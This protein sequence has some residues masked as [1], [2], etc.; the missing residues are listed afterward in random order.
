MAKHSF[1]NLN[2][3]YLCCKRSRFTASLLHDSKLQKNHRQ[4]LGRALSAALHNSSEAP[5][6]LSSLLRFQMLLMSQDNTR[7]VNEIEKGSVESSHYTDKR[8]LAYFPRLNHVAF[9]ARL[10]HSQASNLHPPQGLPGVLIYF[11]EDR[12]L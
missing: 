9:E 8:L 2:E 6:R 11:F 7:H 1:P 5:Y 3:A 10:T 12:V 4:H